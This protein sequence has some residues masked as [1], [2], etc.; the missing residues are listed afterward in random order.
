[1]SQYFELNN[2]FKIPHLGFGTFPM[3]GDILISALKSAKEIGYKLFDTSPAYGNERDLAIGLYRRKIKFFG[4]V[5]RDKYLIQTKLFLDYC[6]NHKEIEGLRQ[7]LKSLN[8][9]YIDIYLMHWADPETFIDNWKAMEKFYKDGLIKT[10][11]VSNMEQHHLEKILDKCEIVPAINQIEITPMLTQKKLMEFCN[12]NNIHVQAYSPFARM[13]EK[14][15]NNQILQDI[16]AKHNKKITQIIL[17]WNIQQ[18]RSVVPKS[19]TPER[20]KENM[21]IYDFEL[22]KEELDMIDSI[23]E[24]FRVRYHPNVY[25]VEWRKENAKNLGVS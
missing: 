4:N 14:L 19:Q 22:S 13:H 18:D 12:Q 21:D 8:T 10:I 16:S 24:D 2:D 6:I 23:N 3:Y 15:F 7:S 5:N 11:G 17:K 9:D 20:L 25:P 1:M